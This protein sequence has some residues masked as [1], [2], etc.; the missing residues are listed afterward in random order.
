MDNLDL[1]EKSGHVLD[2]KLILLE[3]GPETPGE[4]ESYSP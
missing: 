2:V 3:T 4:P 1:Q